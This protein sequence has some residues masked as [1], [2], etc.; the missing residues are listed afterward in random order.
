M[1]IEKLDINSINFHTCKFRS[2]NEREEI[3]RRC[4]CQG[5]DYTIKGYWCE[6][7]QIF[8]VTEDICAE[9]TEYQHK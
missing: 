1:L 4:Q 8:Q 3:V 5:G 2:E 7:R 6:K 9:C